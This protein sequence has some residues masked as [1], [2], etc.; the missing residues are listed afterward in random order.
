MT[1]QIEAKP[2]KRSI[3]MR[4]KQAIEHLAAG[5]SQT[6]AAALSGM[7]RKGLWLALQRDHVKAHL[8]EVA[9]DTLAQAQPR[10]AVRIGEL[11]SSE[12]E[13]VGFQASRLV[14]GIA[15]ISPPE[16]PGV[17][18]NNNVAPGYVINLGNAERLSRRERRNRSRSITS[19]PPAP[20]ARYRESA[21]RRAG[22]R[23]RPLRRLRRSGRPR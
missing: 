15:G 21:T 17:V 8:T 3:S 23:R 20:R 11:M 1:E 9:R 7:S 14:L 12:N 2:R 22:A 6:E 5:K 10:A 18:I 19:R 13:M 4:V 16:R